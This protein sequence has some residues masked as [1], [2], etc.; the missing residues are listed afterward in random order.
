MHPSSR[1]WARVIRRGLSSIT[2]RAT[3]DVLDG[4]SGLWARMAPTTSARSGTRLPCGTAGGEGL[5]DHLVDHRGSAED[6]V[7]LAGEVVEQGAP[8]D[9]GLLGELLH[10]EA[11][12]TAASR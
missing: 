1:W 9:L 6:G 3:G 2:W 7:V 12:E 10:R 11:V 8:G 5:E 4:C